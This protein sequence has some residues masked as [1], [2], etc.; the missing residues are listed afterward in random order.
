MN[1]GNIESVEECMNYNDYLRVNYIYHPDMYPAIKYICLLIFI[2]LLFYIIFQKFKKKEINK[3]YIAV[4]IIFCII[5]ILA[6]ILK[7]K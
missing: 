5:T 7:I 2:A 6:F 3:M 4:C 1:F